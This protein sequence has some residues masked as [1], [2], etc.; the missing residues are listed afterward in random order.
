VRESVK[1]PGWASLMTLLSDTA[2]HS[3]IGEVEALNTATIRRLT[4]SRRH[5]L[6]AIAPNRALC[7]EVESVP[8]Q[9]GRFSRTLR[10]PDGLPHNAFHTDPVRDIAKAVVT[11]GTRGTHVI[12]FTALTRTLPRALDALWDGGKNP[13]LQSFATALLIRAARERRL[14]CLRRKGRLESLSLGVRL[15]LRFFAAAVRHAA[16]PLGY[17]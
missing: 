15:A 11:S 12:A 3:F 8:A 10:L 16:S 9:N 1:A 14:E 13:V 6:L 2:Y 17:L 4:R 5:Q 7:P